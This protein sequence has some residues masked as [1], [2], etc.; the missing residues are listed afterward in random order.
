MGTSY[1]FKCKA[2]GYKTHV[3][4]G[5]SVGFVAVVHTMTC[6]DC[7]ELV[8]VL[9]GREMQVGPTGDPDYDEQLGRC[10][11]CDGRDV[12]KWTAPGPCPKC[13][14]TMDQDEGG[15]VAMWD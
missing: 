6:K 14:E 1:D 8:D 11:E 15:C 7:R 10:P 5:Q 9:T 2:C 13:G 4:G 12:A 3:C